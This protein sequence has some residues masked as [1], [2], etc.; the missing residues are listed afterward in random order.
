MNNPTQTLRI[1][2]LLLL[3][4][5]LIWAQDPDQPIR[6]DNLT[7]DTL[8][9]CGDPVA[10]A[11]GIVIEN[12]VVSKPSDGIKISIVNYLEGEDR[13][14]YTGGQFQSNW[15]ANAGNLELTGLGTADELEEA[16]RQVFYENTSG[17]PSTELRS[18]SISLLDADFLP[19]SGHF[20]Q[21]I[22]QVDI[23]WHEARAA[24]AA[25][26]YY[27]LVG[28]LATITSEA[29]NDFIWSKIDGL[30]W[31]GASDEDVEG[32]WKWVTGPEA[33]TLFWQ[34]DA[35]GMP[36]N[37]RYSS[38][39]EG[40]PNNNYEE[41][42]AHINQD[43]NKSDKT[44]N[45]LAPGGD[46]I[47]GSAYQSRGYVVEFGGM[48]ND[49][50]IQLSA[51]AVIGINELPQEPI[52]NFDAMV[53][54][55]DV[56]E[57]EVITDPDVFSILIPLENAQVSSETSG[58]PVVEVEDYGMY[59]FVLQTYKQIRCSRYDTIEISFNPIPVA[60]LN[61]DD[62][63]C[64]EPNLQLAYVG[65]VRNEAVYSWY[66][67]DTIFDSGLGLV[68][69]EIPVGSGILNQSVGLH[70]NDNGCVD[71]IRVPVT[72]KPVID[73]SA[74]VTE[75]CSPL[76]VQ[77]NYSANEI[78]DQYLWNFGDEEISNDANPVHTF[79]N[80]GSTDLDFDVSLKI[81]T[82]EGC[83]SSDTILNMIVVHPLPSI[84]IGIDESTCYDGNEEIHY[85]GSA[86]SRDT[87]I[88]DLSAFQAGEIIESPG[89]SAGPLVFTLPG[90]PSVDVGLQIISEFGC[91]SDTLV[92]TYNRKPLLNI[93]AD[94]IK[95]CPPLDVTL[96]I[97]TT[98]STD[99]V[100]YMWDFGNGQIMEGGS[101][102]SQSFNEANQV[103]DVAVTAVSSLTGC[104]DSVFLPGKIVTYPAPTIDIG[105]DETA[106]YD[107]N[108]EIWYSGS[109]GSRDS[110]I[111]DLSALQ[112]EEI[113][114]NPGNSTGPLVFT[115]PDRP[116]VDIGLQVITEF[117]CNSDKLV[118]TYTRKPLLDIVAD[119][120]KGCP[121]FDVSL[122]VNTTDFTDEVNYTW[123]LGNG[124][125]FVGGSSFEQIFTEA[126]QI[127]DVSVTAFSSLTGC[128]DS[129]FLPGKIVTYPAPSVDIGIDETTCYHG[130]EEIW[131]SGNAD[132]GDTFVWDLSAFQ[133]GEI[134]ENPGN[135]A[136]P[137]VFTL[138]GRPSVDV[139]LQIISEFGCKSD[140]LFKTY[141]RKPLLDISADI[142]QGCP[143]FDVFLSVNTTDFTD[144]VN[145]IWDLGN[146]A[147]NKRQPAGI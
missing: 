143:P 41:D 23:T 31:I 107:G 3:P 17:N 54:G 78:I 45:D 48:P 130:N 88:W 67:N 140:T 77:F 112:P 119:T 129:L 57:L 108:E 39:S 70:I 53:C 21:Y 121:P 81:V 126:N 29:E 105:I 106:C 144:Q 98:D 36:V 37:N 56:Q 133:P 80:T 69:V 10:V 38:W 35:S 42:Y 24:A 113:I 19:E 125:I 147:N 20:Y 61:I 7:T 44:W 16:V 50:E 60:R 141:T 115:L 83:E 63:V 4:C 99:Q 40:E 96:S 86:G 102:I 142:I 72:V 52:I 32:E 62:A 145:Y 132:T 65:D 58:N 127:Y 100:N 47:P 138:P 122:S 49:P 74:D 9:Y 120:I 5:S 95:G 85:I 43:P 109:A 15:D 8:F 137:L 55:D 92:K 22:Q 68:S 64:V 97:N 6:I 2:F 101:S 117:G 114:E 87:F 104:S 136:G 139:G 89:N 59:R 71:S 93:S 51:S 1:L 90:R 12:F 131:Y 123:D 79:K 11:P 94:T 28:Y 103:Y 13:L 73:F 30:G 111:W 84:D 46:G 26:R 75:G 34:G 116:S 91:K 134:I 18:I 82:E 66:S 27:G 33:G 25:L 14:F 124:Q 146:R 118:K 135:S 128:S 76:K 110:F